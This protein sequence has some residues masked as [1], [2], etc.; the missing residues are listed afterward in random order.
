M[1][2]ATTEYRLLLEELLL[3]NGGS[4]PRGLSTRELISYTTKTDMS[5]PIVSLPSRKLDYTFMVAE[6]YWILSGSDRL[7]HPV[8]R[9][10]LIKYSDDGEI[11]AGAYGPPFAAQV[12]YVVKALSRDRDSRQAVIVI[13][14]MNP[15]N[16]KDIPCT[17]AVQFMIRNGFIHTN[18]FMRSS[19]AWLGW[20]YDV[21]SFTMMTCF[22]AL[23]FPIAMRPKLGTLS[24]TAG[25]QHLY[26][27]NIAQATSV[28]ESSDN[29][30]ILTIG[31]YNLL[32]P[33]CLMNALGSLRN[34]PRDNV[35]AHIKEELC[36]K[37]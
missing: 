12:Q 34:A 21:F 22:V 30:D 13:W 17:V 20:P 16:S 24:L 10:N 32:T 8:L 9:K 29:G 36:A 5:K 23:H 14:R 7:D 4:S 27:R 3:S 26:D 35:L 19:D 25:S 1:S 28:C 31:L 18:V 2:H 33:D 37:P 15:P 6:A 11:M